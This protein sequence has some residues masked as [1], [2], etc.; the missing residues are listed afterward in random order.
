[1]GKIL[2]TSEL[3]EQQLNTLYNCVFG[4]K[5]T[6]KTNKIDDLNKVKVFEC[7]VEEGIELP[8]LSIFDEVETEKVDSVFPIFS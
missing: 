3:N 2:K 4:K 5:P 1:M 6:K 8:K 7:E